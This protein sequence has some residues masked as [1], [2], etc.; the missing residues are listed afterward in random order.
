MT[1]RFQLTAAL[2]ERAGTG[3]LEVDVKPGGGDQQEVPLLDA[4]KA[5]DGCMKGRG[6]PVVKDGMVKKEILVFIKKPEGGQER[7]SDPCSRKLKAG[8]SVLVSS[9]MD[10]G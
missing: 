9:A 10:G 2:K 4:L 7:I 5:L 6:S 3:N 8:E 1:V